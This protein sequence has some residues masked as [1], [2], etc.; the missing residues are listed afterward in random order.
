MKKKIFFLSLLLPFF[1]S[2]CSQPN[3][4]TDSDSDGVYDYEDVCANTPKLA[5][6]DQ[7]GCAKD[8]DNDGVIDLYDKC[9][10]TPFLDIVDSTGCTIKK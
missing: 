2:G 1:I 5:I 7:Y 3:L 9:K 8:S 10:N 6:V 4:Y